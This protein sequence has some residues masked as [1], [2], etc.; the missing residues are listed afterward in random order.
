MNTRKHST[1]TMEVV[2]T[3]DARQVHGG[4]GFASLAVG[5]DDDWCGTVPLKFRPPKGPFPPGGVGG[6]GGLV[7]IKNIGGF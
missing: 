1:G 2:A 4:M 5:F 7:N 3:T 6:L